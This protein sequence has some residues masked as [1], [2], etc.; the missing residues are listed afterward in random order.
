MKMDEPKLILLHVFEPKWSS[1]AKILVLRLMFQ[2]FMH[3]GFGH[4]Y[5]RIRA[6]NDEEEEKLCP[7]I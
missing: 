7:A 1:Q 4:K 6:G 2:T 5:R 3:Y